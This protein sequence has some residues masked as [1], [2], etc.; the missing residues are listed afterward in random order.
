LLAS[1]WK[2][3]V[4]LVTQ[5][6]HLQKN[7]DGTLDTQNPNGD[8]DPG[9]GTV[10]WGDLTTIANALAQ[11][12]P[13]SSLSVNVRAALTGSA[14]AV[15]TIGVITDFG[16]DVTTAG[17]NQPG[18]GNN[19]TNS[20]AA[21]GGGSLR[22]TATVS[23][24]TVTSDPIAWARVAA[25]ASDVLAPTKG[26]GLLGTPKIGGIDWTM[27]APCDPHDGTH[28]GSGV[29]QIDLELNGSVVTVAC[30]PGITAAPTKTNIG[31]ISSPGAP[32]AVQSG[33][34]WTLTAAGIGIDG[35]A[36]EGMFLNWQV[37]GD[38]S[39]TAKIASFTGTG[40]VFAPAALMIR[41]D[42]TQGSK[43]V[44]LVQ[45]LS[46]LSQGLQGKQRV[47]TGGARATIAS[48]TGS[49]S[50]FY[51]RLER[52]GDAFTLFYSADGL[53]WTALASTTVAMTATVYL[54]V[55]VSSM[56]AGSNVAAEF[57]DVNPSTT[58]RITYSQT[59]AVAVTA[60]LR[61]QDLAGTPNVGA[62]SA[63][64]PSVSPLA[65]TGLI[66]FNPGIY[67]IVSTIDTYN[68]TRASQIAPLISKGVKGYTYWTSWR[69]LE[70]TRGT[71]NFTAMRAARDAL[72]A[73]GLRMKVQLQDRTFS[74]T[75][76]RCPDYLAT[77]V[78]SGGIYTKGTGGT[79]PKYWEPTGKIT[80]RWNAL[81][82]ALSDEFD[83]EAILEGIRGEESDVSF[84]SS[85]WTAA[86]FDSAVYLQQLLRHI[87]YISTVFPTTI[88]WMG[89][90]FLATQTQ[91]ETLAKYTYDRTA[92]GFGIAPSDL[93]PGKRT[94]WP[95]EIYLG[96][97]WTG[98]WSPGGT[99]YRGKALYA[100]QVQD[101]EMGGKAGNW[102][103]SEFY[104]EAVA[105]LSAYMDPWDKDYTWT[106]FSFPA[107]AQTYWQN[108]AAPDQYRW[109]SYLGTANH[110]MNLAIPTPLVGKT[111]AG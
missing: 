25:P 99:D 49:N 68:P 79:I 54:G 15:A 26:T 24:N 21:T 47:L 91:F 88:K 27:D 61:A 19:L 32:T 95:L 31:S 55:F 18:S 75:S 73:L 8:K 78:A 51:V 86:G 97:T 35:T 30:P 13:S 84:S 102:L 59:T 85:E 103:P 43:Y 56:Q 106:T 87:D 28:V 11:T 39:I 96:N 46:Q 71:Y 42:L 53:A 17:F 100:P 37:S 34:N 33:R 50:A 20:S 22:L 101:P 74:G 48:L 4:S 7:P 57:D 110:P 81:W 90:N 109:L 77:E 14:A 107:N 44:A 23:G 111:T 58:P 41:E 5:S 80:D 76:R 38:C 62:Y 16:T 9:P 10:S 12:L 45:L 72:K 63:L 105:L 70:P 40:N 2:W 29:K 52:I 83:S 89:W 93:I 82:K 36:D 98:A 94:A 67:P 66:K 65:A 104:A 64:S 60:R 3:L 1:F 92:L 6:Y 108:T 69:V